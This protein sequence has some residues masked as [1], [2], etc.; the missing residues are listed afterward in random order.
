MR[1]RLRTCVGECIADV[2]LLL[3]KKKEKSFLT[4][5]DPGR[6]RWVSNFD[7]LEYGMVTASHRGAMLIIETLLSLFERGTNQRERIR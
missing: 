1:A 5:N 3:A 6:D 2:F 4:A 7:V